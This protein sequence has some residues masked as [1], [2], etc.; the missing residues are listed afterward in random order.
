MSFAVAHDPARRR[1]HDTCAARKSAWRH[2][3]RCRMSPASSRGMCD[4]I[5]AR[6]F[7][8]EKVIEPGEVVDGAGDQRPDRLQPPLPGDGR[9]DDDRGAF[10]PLAGP[11][12]GVHRRRQQRRA[13]AGRR[14]A[15][16]SGCASSSP[17]PRGMSCRATTST[18]HAQVP[19]HGFRRHQRS[20][21]RPCASADV[22]DTDTWVSM[23]QE[24]EKEERI[25]DFAGFSVDER[26]LGAAPKHA[27]V[28]HCLPAYRG[29]GDQRRRD[30]RPAV[31]SSRRRRTACTSKGSSGGADGRGV[32]QSCRPVII[33]LGLFLLVA[34]CSSGGP[35]ATRDFVKPTV[36]VMKFE[37]RAAFPMLGLGQRHPRYPGGSADADQPL[38]RD[39]AP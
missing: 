12:A 34:G 24:A 6:T 5:M 8:H 38:S 28:L 22:V 16:D 29:Y 19:E 35:R 31:S 10:R 36:A 17:R 37:N 15:G 23:G 13:L 3:S 27:V 9:P 30:G 14:R 11:D 1:R 4:G 26:L 25:K 33:L 7:E 32:G 2:A 21:S 39:R 18:D 20:A